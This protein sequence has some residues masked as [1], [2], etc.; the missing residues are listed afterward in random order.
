[1]RMHTG[2]NLHECEVCNK[3][4]PSKDGLAGHM[5]SHNGEKPYECEVCKKKFSKLQFGYTYEN[6][7]WWKTIWM[8]YVHKEPF[9]AV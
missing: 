1:M 2:E 5:R 6:P 9:F 8:L 7:H 4:F 3:K